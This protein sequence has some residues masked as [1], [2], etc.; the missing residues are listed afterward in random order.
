MIDEIID[1]VEVLA[2]YSDQADD[3]ASQSKQWVRRFQAIE[4]NSMLIPWFPLD[5]RD[6]QSRMAIE[7]A[8]LAPISNIDLSMNSL[9]LY[10]QN[11]CASPR[12]EITY[13][14]IPYRKR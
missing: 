10:L 7:H 9:A 14:D 3:S 8:F 5:L 13:C 6:S 1:A 4:G 11:R 2:G 12:R